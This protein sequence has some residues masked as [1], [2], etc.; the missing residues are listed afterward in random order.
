[1]PSAVQMATPEVIA[2]FEASAFY[3]AKLEQNTKLMCALVVFQFVAIPNGIDIC[4]VHCTSHSINFLMDLH[5]YMCTAL[6]TAHSV[7]EVM[8]RKEADMKN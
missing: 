3:L 7:K 6:F 2:V 1:M 8:K 4:D 5:H